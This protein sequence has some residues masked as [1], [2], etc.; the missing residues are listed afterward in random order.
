MNYVIDFVASGNAPK[1]SQ[2]CYRSACRY[3]FAY[4]VANIA[5]ICQWKK[6]IAVF[7]LK[8]RKK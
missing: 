2:L 4:N 8:P 7:F 1:N 5:I 3:R 6:L